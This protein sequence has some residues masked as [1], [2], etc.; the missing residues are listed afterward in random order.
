MKTALKIIGIVFG[1]IVLLVVVAAI[2]FYFITGNFITRTFDVAV[3]PVD[4]PAGDEVLAHGQHLATI[5][6]CTDCHGENLAGQ[7]L[8]EDPVMGYLYASNL[9]SGKGGVGSTFTPTDWVRAI[10]HGVRPNGQSLIVMPS[11]DFYYMSDRDLGAL[12]AYIKS[13]PP[14]DHEMPAR[15]FGPIGRMLL[16]TEAIPL[17]AVKVNHTAPRPEPDPGVT[18]EYGSYLASTCRGCHGPKLNGLGGDADPNGPPPPNLTPSGEL[19]E[20][21]EQDFI[22]TL[23]TGKTPEGDELD[24]LY[25]PWK[26]VGQMTDDELKAVFMYLQSLPP[27]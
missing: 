3:E 18:V 16:Y 9:T 14:V 6:G 8:I 2:V 15:S 23:R 27:S 11:L 25:M 12:L 10:R 22:N 1:V 24:P 4:I 13:V 26:A 7:P 21:S 17:Q 5:W 20:W 19:G